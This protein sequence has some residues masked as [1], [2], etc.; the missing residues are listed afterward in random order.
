MC[1]Q[2]GKRAVAG[3]ILECVHS[4]CRSKIGGRIKGRVV[5]LAADGWSTLTNNPGILRKLVIL[6]G[7]DIPSPS[8]LGR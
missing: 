6:A 1:R 4:E 2:S 8:A 5:T 3:D 7:V